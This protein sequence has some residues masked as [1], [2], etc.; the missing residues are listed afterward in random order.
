MHLQA[1]GDARLVVDQA[2]ELH[3]E[4]IRERI[5]ESGKK[6][7][8]VGIRAGKMNGTVKRDDGLPGAGRS[9]D[10]SRAAVSALHNPTLCR[11]QEDGPLF[12]RIF[13]CLFQFLR[14]LHEAEAALCLRV[15]ERVSVGG[16]V[17]RPIR[18]A[19]GR[20]LHQCFP[21]LGRKVNG[22]IE[23]RIL[24]SSPNVIQPRL[25]HAVT[26]QHV[27]GGVGEERWFGGWA[28]GDWRFHCRNARHFNLA[29][30]LA[31]FDDL[32]RTGLG[33]PLDPAP[34]RPSVRRVVM[35]DIGEHDARCG[36]MHDQ[37]NVPVD[38]DGPEILILR[39][40]ELV[41]R[42]TRRRR[43][44]LQVEGGGLRGFLLVAGQPS[45]TV[46]KG[47]G[48]L[49]HGHHLQDLMALHGRLPSSGRSGC[50]RPSARG[51]DAGSR[52]SG[53]APAQTAGT[54]GGS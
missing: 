39:P 48:E 17:H 41:K 6:D 16:C 7:S 10:T 21:C 47:V 38:P 15:G 24:V 35:A 14:I 19:A 53:S 11:M 31:D 23:H 29:H 49:E 28:R 13:E 9:R 54:A 4:R 8:G 43:V 18:R 45:Q 34:F 26:Q 33:M 51:E 32:R 5:R 20:Q 52:A 3:A 22:N 50:N 2:P 12:P 36:P 42:E 37:A 40:V 30:G 46:G 44:Q 25:G 27:V 1:L